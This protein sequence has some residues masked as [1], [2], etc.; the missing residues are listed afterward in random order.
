MS[1]ITKLLFIL[2]QRK[3]IT[4][5]DLKKEGILYPL[6][7]C[8]RVLRSQNHVFLYKHEKH[9]LLTLVSC[10]NRFK[11]KF[12]KKDNVFLAKTYK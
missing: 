4:N 5:K 9:D 6:F 2:R 12:N 11:K 3:I 8:V 10:Y 1:R 7:C